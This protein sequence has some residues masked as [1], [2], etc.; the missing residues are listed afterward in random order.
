[1][2]SIFTLILPGEVKVDLTN[3]DFK[4]RIKFLFIGF[5]KI[6]LFLQ[7]RLVNLFKLLT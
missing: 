5:L 4:F 6:D 1:M 2:Q 7:K 3:F